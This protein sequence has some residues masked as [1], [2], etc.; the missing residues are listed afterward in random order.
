MRIADNDKDENETKSD[1][2]GESR[3]SATERLHPNMTKR[4]K[5]NYPGSDVAKERRNDEFRQSVIPATAII[6]KVHI[7]PSFG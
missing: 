4:D 5:P 3:L 7:P 6:T 1:L 2:G